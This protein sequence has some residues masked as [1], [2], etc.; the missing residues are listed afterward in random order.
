MPN[1]SSLASSSPLSPIICETGGP[2]VWL[3]TQLCLVAGCKRP[4]SCKTLHILFGHRERHRP[5]EQFLPRPV[6]SNA[7]E[8]DYDVEDGSRV[9]TTL[10]YKDNRDLQFE[11]IH[12]LRPGLYGV[13]IQGGNQTLPKWISINSTSPD[14]HPQ[15]QLRNDSIF[16]HCQSG[17][18]VSWVLPN[19]SLQILHV[20][21]FRIRVWAIN[22]GS[23]EESLMEEFPLNSV[24]KGNTIAI[25]CAQFDI[26]FSKFCFELISIEK[27]TKHFEL[28][29]KKCV[30][31]E[32]VS[33]QH[34]HLESSWSEWSA[35]SKC[36]SR[37]FS[38]PQTGYRKR[39][40]HCIGVH[41]N[42]YV[43]SPSKDNFCPG[44]MLHKENCSLITRN[45]DKFLFPVPMQ[46]NVRPG[47]ASNNISGGCEC[48]CDLRKS[49]GLIYIGSWNCS[50]NNTLKWTLKTTPGQKYTLEVLLLFT[51]TNGR[52]KSKSVEEKL[53]LLRNNQMEVFWSNED[54]EFASKD[55]YVLREPVWDDVT[56]QFTRT[57][58]GSVF[59]RTHA[60]GIYLDYKLNPIEEIGIS[61]TLA[62]LILGNLANLGS[63]FF[64]CDS[65]KTLAFPE[66]NCKKV[67][68]M[69]TALGCL[70]LALLLVVI[71]PLCCTVITKKYTEHLIELHR[72]KKGRT[73]SDSDALISSYSQRSDMQR[74]GDTDCT[75]LAS[76]HQPQ[77]LCKLLHQCQLDSDQGGPGNFIAGSIGIQLSRQST[78]RSTSRCLANI[79]QPVSSTTGSSSAKTRR[80]AAA[81]LN[82]SA[83][84]GEE[85]EEGELE[86]D[87][88]EPAHLPFLGNSDDKGG[89]LEEYQFISQID[90][91]QIVRRETSGWLQELEQQNK[92]KLVQKQDAHTQ[93]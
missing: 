49:V 9:L 45:V 22:S 60:N 70:M 39:R 36:S 30:S 48:G 46:L 21:D 15:L 61:D 59:Q 2:V 52:L 87:Y 38:N 85:E 33:S 73:S 24:A 69:V 35:W 89:L 91:D 82:N 31:T 29:D 42:T 1:W 67:V 6:L 18:I 47:N 32:P 19:C 12:F 11:C 72:R 5:F 75:H 79:S 80:S 78:P 63:H 74:S 81:S 71:P 90:I 84:G 50:V 44:Y 54:V 20:L 13:G 10:Y 64:D 37:G 65:G 56:V 77:L 4:I 88:Y 3:L 34:Q 25:P 86:Y 27:K 68:A 53:Q 66:S 28:W 16:P 93:I 26:I 14:Q 62:R 58:L 55:T 7:Q 17:L 51:A 23:M 40:R 8:L 92:D 83:T 43:A 57:S 76:T 41:T